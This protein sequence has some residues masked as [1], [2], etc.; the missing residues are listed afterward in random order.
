MAAL[1]GSFCMS[2]NAMVQPIKTEIIQNED[3]AFSMLRDGE[4]Y[5]VNGVGG[6]SRLD[7][8]V[9]A[10]GNSIRTWGVSKESPEILDQAHER[11]LS[12]TFGLW[13]PHERHGFD[14]NN[15][16]AVEKMKREMLDAVK[17]FK[18]HPAVL[19][20]G[21]G[22]ELNLGYTNKKVWDEVN[23]L[24]LRI[25]EID[26][27]HPVMTVTAGWGNKV[28]TDIKKQAPALDLIGINAYGSLPELPEALETQG[29]NKP[30]LV[31]EWGPT[32]HWEVPTTSWGAP[33][34]ET[35]SRKAAVYKDRYQKVIA[36]DIDRCLGSYAFLWGQ[37]QERTPTWYGL[38]LESGHYTQVLDVMRELWQG[39]YFPNRAPS[40]R[41]LTI[42]G[43]QASESVILNPDQSFTARMNAHDPDNDS[44]R[45]EW[46]ILRESESTA[47]GGDPEEKPESLNELILN[48][49]AGSITFQSPKKTGNY[50]LFGYVYDGKKRAATA[51]I[52]FRVN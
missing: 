16:E 52:P 10:G 9:E 15:D 47:E 26:P 39:D 27:N 40:V 34:E 22:N 37:K 18:D 24:A 3:G 17:A 35:S 20:W 12:V 19:V 50:R 21:L 13:L 1:L 11:G 25:K 51:N 44:L 38:F 43:Q 23:D 41:S 45:Y 4:P 46:V 31:T 36:A 29:W 48:Q 49:N 8:L 28:L 42:A 30:Y 14:Y 33:I 5:F 6:Q 2:L 32:G 7:L